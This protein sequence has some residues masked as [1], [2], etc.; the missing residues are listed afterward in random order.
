MNARVCKNRASK[1][2][3]VLM[4]HPRL[5]T[6]ER[7]LRLMKRVLTDV[8]RDTHTA[9]GMKHPLSQHTIEG[10]RDCLALISARESELAD[11]AGRKQSDRP[12]F[13]DEP[14]KAH[15]VSIESIRRK[16]KDTD[17]GE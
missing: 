12:H 3:P 1:A 9:P 5:S 16:K 14:K 11:A 2:E 6:E 10:I 15:T 7:I 8:A 13:T 17:H 4:T